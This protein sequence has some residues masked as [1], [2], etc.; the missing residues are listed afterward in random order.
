V[1]ES[2]ITVWPGEAV[3]DLDRQ[4]HPSLFPAADQP[5]PPF[6]AHD[7]RQSLGGGDRQAAERVA[8]EIYDRF[9]GVELEP[10]AERGEWIG[11][12]QRGGPV[13]DDT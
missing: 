9:A 4:V 1:V 11:P 7:V 12:V 6:A 5:A 10:F 8:V 13:L 3:P 2:P